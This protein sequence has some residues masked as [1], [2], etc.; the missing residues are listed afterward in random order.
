VFGTGLFDQDEIGSV[1]I[2]MAARV[3]HSYYD[4]GTVPG[5]PAPDMA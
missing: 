3:T 1:C 2:F 5:V 4:H